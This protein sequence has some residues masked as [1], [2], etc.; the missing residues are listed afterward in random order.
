MH[1]R[2]PCTGRTTSPQSSSRNVTVRPVCGRSDGSRCPP[3]GGSGP[4]VSRSRPQVVRGQRQ[5][6]SCSPSTAERSSLGAVGAGGGGAGREAAGLRADR[7]RVRAF[8][9]GSGSPILRSSSADHP[10]LTAALYALTSARSASPTRCAMRASSS[11]RSRSVSSRT[12]STSSHRRRAGSSTRTPARRSN[13]SPC[14]SGTRHRG[15]PSSR[16]PKQP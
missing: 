5:V 4:G 6:A 11:A 8:L 10:A 1:P 12:T 7:R 13:P 16:R 15:S 9:S 2:R 14:L 3:V